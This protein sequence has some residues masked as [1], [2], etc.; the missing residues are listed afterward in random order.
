MRFRKTLTLLTLAVG[1]VFVLFAR[2][3]Q[4]PFNQEQVQA[5]VRD[6]F[7][8][9]SGAKLIVERGIDFEPSEGFLQSLKAAGADEV[10][11]QALRAPS[12]AQSHG[13]KPNRPLN[14]LQIFALLAGQVSSHRITML[15][16]ERAID[17]DPKEEYLEQIRIIGG[18]DEL[19]SALKNAKVM[20]PPSVELELQAQ[21]LRDEMWDEALASLKEAVSK[22]QFDPV[23]RVALGEAL[24]RTG[25]YEHAIRELETAKKL[26]TNLWQATQR[27]ADA[28]LKIWE[29][30]K[31]GA[32]RV[33]T[34]ELY[35]ELLSSVVEND[36]NSTRLAAL[37]PKWNDENAEKTEARSKLAEL[38][39]PVGSWETERG[40][41]YFFK[42]D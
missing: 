35:Q 9:E 26:D 40:E 31:S 22:Q 36:A 7:G 16:Q 19:I 18:D 23:L 2:A 25:D 20:K 42:T 13:E 1:L 38:E 12:G 41:L 10:F 17:F 30:K 8:D 6:G 27:M 21:Y 34:C 3:Q 37:F 29:L 33:L 5:M 14:Q 39:S 28:H 11:L 4:K 15:V 32:D 24:F